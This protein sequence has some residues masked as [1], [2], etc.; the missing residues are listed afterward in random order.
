MFSTDQFCSADR[1][2]MTAYRLSSTWKA[3]IEECESLKTMFAHLPYPANLIVSTVKRFINNQAPGSLPSQPNENCNEKGGTITFPL[4][5]KD[6][7]SADITTKQLQCL[8]NKIGIQLQPVFPSRKI[9]SFL[10]VREPKPD[11]V[12]QQCV[13]YHFQ[14]GLCDLDNVGYTKRHLHQRVAEL[15]ELNNWEAHD[16]TR[17]H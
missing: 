9:G 7:K 14:C 15:T 4:R 2:T 5:S 17:S 13:V 8:S 10:K 6:Q 16:E 1:Q 3:L 12:S 11:I